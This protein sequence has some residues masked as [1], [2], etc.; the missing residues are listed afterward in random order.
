M[1]LFVELEEVEYTNNRAERGIRPSVV[2]RKIS[3]GN[4]SD[5]GAR[6][7]E[8]LMSIMQTHRLQGKDFF[9]EA[10][11]YI[12]QTVFAPTGRQG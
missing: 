6:A 11:H 5:R 8:V 3:G 10:S 12:N 1:F 9:A 4:R 7:H 2:M